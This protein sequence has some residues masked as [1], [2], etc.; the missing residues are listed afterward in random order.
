M[1]NAPEWK[2]PVDSGDTQGSMREIESA[3]SSDAAAAAAKSTAVPMEIDSSL[4]A[5]G[6]K[7]SELP[8]APAAPS[9][10]ATPVTVPPP[11]RVYYTQFKREDD[12]FAIGDTVSVFSPSA[13]LSRAFILMKFA[14]SMCRGRC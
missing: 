12:D 5:L 8:A 4:S 11:A 6:Q 1:Q 7:P 3:Q 2:L 9:T 10:P 13:L 14:V